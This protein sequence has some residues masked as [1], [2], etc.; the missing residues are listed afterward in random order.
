MCDNSGSCSGK[1]LPLRSEV[2]KAHHGNLN[3][4]HGVGLACQ[5]TTGS[6]LITAA[7]ITKPV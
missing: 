4:C 5:G 2:E 6:G 7:V 1:M 3:M